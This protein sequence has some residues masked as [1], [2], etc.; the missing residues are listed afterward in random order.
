[1][2]DN[3]KALELKR[4]I[5]KQAIKGSSLIFW[6]FLSLVLLLVWFTIC[7]FVVYSII[8]E[9]SSR[10]LWPLGIVFIIISILISVKLLPK[11]VIAIVREVFCTYT[12]A[13]SNDEIEVRWSS[14]IYSGAKRYKR[15]TLR[16]GWFGC[17]RV[18][19]L[20]FGKGQFVF[21]SLFTKANWDD[22]EKLLNE[23]RAEPSPSL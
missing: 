17:P 7:V 12:I 18:P 5:D 11:L 15:N 20:A 22:V 6:C 23:G 1:M 10:K 21:G 4:G 13:I 3:P 19:V 14:V 16:I 8:N 2:S 9:P